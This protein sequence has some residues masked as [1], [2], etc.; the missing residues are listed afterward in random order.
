[1][2]KS[3]KVA[4]YLILDND[5]IIESITSSCMCNLFIDYK[6]INHRKIRFNELFP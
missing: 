5:E 6:M 2:V 3:F 4:C 1:M